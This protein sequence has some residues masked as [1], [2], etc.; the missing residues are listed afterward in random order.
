M[1]NLFWIVSWEFSYPS[2]DCSGSNK[3]MIQ[4]GPY[5]RRRY[6]SLPWEV[7]AAIS[8]CTNLSAWASNYLRTFDGVPP[9]LAI[10]ARNGCV[11]TTPSQPRLSLTQFHSREYNPLRSFQHGQ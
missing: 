10:L 1:V 5:L 11:S 9:C 4:T 3:F 2:M 8:L 6:P 7:E